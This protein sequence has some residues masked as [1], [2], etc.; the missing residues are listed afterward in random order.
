MGSPAASVS[1]RIHHVIDALNGAQG[2]PRLAVPQLDPVRMQGL[3]EWMDEMA[4]RLAPAHAFTFENVPVVP[5]DDGTIDLPGCAGDALAMVNEG[6]IP[7]PYPVT[8]FEAP[9]V[10][11]RETLCFLLEEMD[12]GRTI[13]TPFHFMRMAG[14]GDVL[15][16]T[17]ESWVIVRDPEAD[18]PAIVPFDP[19]GG[20][21]LIHGRSGLSH[22]DR[23]KGESG[24]VLYLLVMLCSKTTE[25]A[26]EPPPAKLNKA[27]AKKGKAPLPAVTRVSIIPKGI[28]AA[29]R[30]DG[31]G[32]GDGTVRASPRL[33][34]R[35][36]HIRRLADGKATKVVRHL[37]G[38]KSAD[39]SEIVPREYVVRL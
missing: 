15:Q 23:I 7:V 29:M 13:V 25:A 27:R 11:G 17:G 5:C 8:W 16:V 4:L 3:T 39:G 21:E 37:V 20:A 10:E 24:F 18:R 33:H 36:S 14:E 31:E 35:R 22:V 19:F 6:M 1:M 9:T 32:H 30:R 12:E 2:A 34:W 26:T 38:Y 28:A